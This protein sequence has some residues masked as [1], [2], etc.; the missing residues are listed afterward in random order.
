MKSTVGFI[1]IGKKFAQ[2][3]QCHYTII[4]VLQIAMTV[5]GLAKQDDDCGEEEERH[6]FE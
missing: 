5:N 2:D 4:Y 1:S 3:I 6:F